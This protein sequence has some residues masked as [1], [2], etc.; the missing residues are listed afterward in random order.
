MPI[1]CSTAG[2]Q[3]NG[4]P[5]L[6][7]PG[8]IVLCF[9]INDVRTGATTQAQ[10]VGL[11][12][13]AVD[14]IRAVLPQT[15]IVLWGPNSFLQDDVGGAGYISPNTAA[16]AQTY[17]TLL[18]GAYEQLKN[19]WP[20][21]LVLQK[22]DILGKTCAT[23]AALGAS[24]ATSYMADQLHPGLGAQTQMAD[25]LAPLIGFKK[26]FN[27]QRAA[28]ARVANP[29]APYLVYPREV[30]DP[31]LYD[32]VGQ[33]AWVGQGNVS[34]N[35]YMDFTFPGPRFKEILAGDIVQMG[36]GG[37]VF[38]MPLTEVTLYNLNSTTTRLGFT[39][40]GLLPSFSG[41]VVT[42]YRHKYEW[43]ATIQSYAQQLNAYPYR[44]RFYVAAAGA[45]FMRLYPLAQNGRDPAN[46]ILNPATDVIVPSGGFG[47]ITGY[48]A[49]AFQ[50]VG[51]WQVSKTGTDL[52]SLMGKY[53]WVFSTF[54]QREYMENNFEP[55]RLN[56]PGSV[57]NSAYVR[58]I[59]VRGAG[60]VNKISYTQ[61]TAGT[62]DMTITLKVAGTLV[63]TL[64]VTANHVGIQ[65]TTW[66][67]GS[68]F[69]V[70]PNQLIE[71]NVTGGTG[72]ADVA[73]ALDIGG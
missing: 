33:G 55:I 71:W 64:L 53:V 67:S 26:P 6:Q 62:T 28:L 29:P 44:R 14:R 60:K 37:A 13:K 40:T 63:L 54:P 17:S 5:A 4:T 59:A 39:G 41:G 11:I 47:A 1:A 56:A 68:S 15:D 45:S 38:Q 43:D 19:T 48:S 46:M 34:G 2:A 42:V 18:Y 52:S 9:G 7:V 25:W 8:L 24:S 31:A 73:V 21:V 30:E 51:A 32:V 22:Q 66:A 36:T 69:A 20:N 49:L 27:S 58:Q 57:A 23:Y 16:A 61:G 35:D 72:A 50:S 12:R 65:T 10:L 3:I 70:F